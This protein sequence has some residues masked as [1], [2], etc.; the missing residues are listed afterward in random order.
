MFSVAWCPLRVKNKTE[1]EDKR[2][3]N[4]HQYK[5]FSKQEVS[6]MGKISTPLRLQ[7]ALLKHKI[8]GAQKTCKILSIPPF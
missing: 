1:K 8:I 7:T 4:V 6:Y 5:V 2:R 3:F